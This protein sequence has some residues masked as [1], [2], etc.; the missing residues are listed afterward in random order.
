MNRAFTNEIASSVQSWQ[1]F[2][3]QDFFHETA[4]DKLRVCVSSESPQAVLTA[5]IIVPEMLNE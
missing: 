4:V 5:F 3:F 2:L 1:I